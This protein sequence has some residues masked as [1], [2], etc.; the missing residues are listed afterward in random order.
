M[1]LFCPEKMALLRSAPTLVAV[2]VEGGD[3][4]EIA[5]VVATEHHVHEAGNDLARLRA[6]VVLHT[7]DERARAV[8]H[9]GDGH[10]DL[11]HESV[12][13][14][15]LAVPRGACFWRSAS[16]SRSSQSMSCCVTSVLCST[17]ERM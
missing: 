1:V 14:V 6:A 16:M 8:A 13:F 9:A 10:S 2:D 11:A 12:P 4:L 3:E 17:S 5:H 7:L 15:A